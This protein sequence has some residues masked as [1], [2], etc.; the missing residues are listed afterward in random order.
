M[1]LV[2]ELTDAGQNFSSDTLTFTFD[3]GNEAKLTI[4]SADA[5]DSPS[6][7]VD[8]TAHTLTSLGFSSSVLTKTFY[9][10]ADH[11][12]RTSITSQLNLGGIDCADTVLFTAIDDIAPT[13]YCVSCGAGTASSQEGEVH[14][15]GFE[16]YGLDRSKSLREKTEFGGMT[17]VLLAGNAIIVQDAG[18]LRIYDF[19]HQSGST[20]TLSE[21]PRTDLAVDYQ[22]TKSGSDYKETDPY[23]TVRTFAGNPGGL[24]SVDRAGAVDE[25]WTRNATTDL[26]EKLSPTSATVRSRRPS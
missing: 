15:V 16:G 22:L 25:T 11:I 8:D 5:H 19:E 1:P 14:H 2:V 13:D 12:G 3:A 26:L 23:G 10:R 9:V 21:S 17:E 7:I 24:L 20:Y 6:V 18:G 4:Y